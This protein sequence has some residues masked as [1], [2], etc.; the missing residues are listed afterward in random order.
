V[1][2]LGRRDVNQRV[3]GW[4]VSTI[5]K[6]L[7]FQEMLGILEDNLVKIPEHR[8]GKNCQYEIKEAGLA[9]FSVFFMQSPSFLAHQRDMQRKKGKNNV[10]GLFGIEQIPSDG[11]I[12]NILD[13]VSP[14]QL[15]EPFWDVY[16]LLKANEQLER[17]QGIRG[18]LLISLDGSQYFSSQKIHCPN[19]RVQI[20]DGKAYYSHSVMAAVLC[21]PG[22]E[23]VICLDPE[24]ITPQDGH[25]K[26]D[27]EQQAIKRWV[28]RN[29][30]R[31]EPWSVTILG[32]DLHCHQPT[33]E[34]LLKHRLHFILTCKPE[35]HQAL[36]E[37][38]ALLEKVEGAI[39]TMTVRHWNGRYYEYWTY[40]WAERLPLRTTAD[41]LWVNWCEL[42]I[43]NEATGEQLYHSSWA[44]DHDIN[45]ESVVEIVAGGRSRWKVENEGFNVLK[46]RGYNF[47]HN[48]GHGQEYLAALLLT[49]LLLAFLFHT[50]LD[51]TCL[52]YQAVHQEL[53]RRRTFFNDL[54]ALTRYL[55]FSSWRQLLRFMYLGLDLAPG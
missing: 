5:G 3:A 28:E 12:R 54:R 24:F 29:S 20:R 55:Y 30:Q 26:Q 2:E 22:E 27:C 19:C 50:A 49:L 18:T 47:E 53:G 34:L 43:I 42:T 8:T 36:Y 23:H 15:R 33:C 38:L 4:E 6:E 46:N 48:Y 45:E 32:D 40:R 13:P 11:Q 21:A 37:E 39:S 7:K 35:S 31:F 14:S 17:Y 41:T 51:L 16:A 52:I 10:Q 9:A 44:T 1:I 25:E